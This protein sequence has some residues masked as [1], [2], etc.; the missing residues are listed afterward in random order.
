MTGTQLTLDAPVT[1]IAAPEH[2]LEV[3]QPRPAVALHAVRERPRRDGRGHA[4]TGFDRSQRRL[5]GRSTCSTPRCASGAT[6]SSSPSPRLRRGAA[7]G[8]L[9]SAIERHGL[10]RRRHRHHRRRRVCA[11]TAAD[12]KLGTLNADGTLTGGSILSSGTVASRVTIVA[13]NIAMAATT[14]TCTAAVQAKSID[15]ARGR[16]RRRESSRPWAAT[17]PSTRAGRTGTS[18]AT[19]SPRAATSPAATDP[20]GATV[21]RRV[22]CT[23]AAA[24]RVAQHRSPAAAHTGAEPRAQ[25]RTATSSCTATRSSLA[26]NLNAARG[27]PRQRDG[28]R[29]RSIDP[30]R[31]RRSTLGAD[32]RRSISG[33]AVDGRRQDQRGPKTDPNDPT[34]D[35]IQRDVDLAL[36]LEPADA[37]RR[38]RR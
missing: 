17:S 34:S 9:L 5:T 35:E 22:P 14:L 10:D 27:R 24:S 31:R 37:G 15:H 28:E 2:P 32:T 25:R 33:G 13:D 20:G 8:T 19:C 18:S 7:N 30:A 38:R 16:P 1:S 3:E 36:R 23:T 21:G 11:S 29:N 4:G 6:S 12:V 26:G